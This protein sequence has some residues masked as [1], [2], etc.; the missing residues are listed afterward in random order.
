MNEDQIT[1]FNLRNKFH[2]NGSEKSNDFSDFYYFSK[3]INEEI[4]LEEIKKSLLSSEE[5]KELNKK[6]VNMDIK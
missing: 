6:L 2:F 1:L 3:D 5:N 4:N